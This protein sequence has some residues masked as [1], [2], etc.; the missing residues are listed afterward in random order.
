M[1][2]LT[3]IFNGNR[4]IEFIITWRLVFYVIYIAVTILLVSNAL[5]HYYENRTIMVIIWMI[6]FMSYPFS[7]FLIQLKEVW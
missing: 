6:F 3:D 5:V 7:L 4:K 2:L 1:K